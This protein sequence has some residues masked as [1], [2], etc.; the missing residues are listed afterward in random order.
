MTTHGAAPGYRATTTLPLR[1][2]LVRQLRRRR[3]VL[4]LGFLSE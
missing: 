2:E 4:T 3:T 1:V